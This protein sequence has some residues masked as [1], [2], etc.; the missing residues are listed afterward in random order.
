MP[1]RELN[2]QWDYDLKASP[3]ELW[4]FVSDTNR[5]NRD[6]GVPAVESDTKRHRLRNARRRL[7]LSI[8]GMAV[9]WEEQPFEWIR[10]SRFGVARTYSRG[11]MT[12]L[13][14]LAELTPRAGGG[15][16]LS[17]RVW[18][19]PRSLLGALVVRFQVRLVNAKRFARAFRKYDQIASTETS[20]PEIATAVDLAP[21][22]LDRFLSIREKL[23]ADGARADVVDLLLSFV[24][25]ADDYRVARIRPYELADEWNLPRRAVLETCLRSTR[26][27][28]FDLQWE[29][30]CPLCRGAGETGSS[31]RDISSQVHC[32]TCRIDFTV[33]FDRF[34]EVTFRPNALIRRVEVQQFCMGSP[35]FTPHIVAQ[36]LLP[37]QTQRAVS[38]PL[39]PGRY[40]LRALELAGGQDVNVSDDGQMSATVKITEAGWPPEEL[41]LATQTTLQIANNTA[42]EQLVILE[43]LA[44]SD[45][46]ATAAEV[47]ALQIFRDLFSSEA[48]R[49]GEQ[50]SVGTL[51]ILFTDLRNSTQLYRQIGDATAFG[52]VMNHFD[53]LKQAIGEEDGALVKTIGDAVM[54]VFRRPVSAL[55]SMLRAQQSLASPPEGVLPLTLKAGIHCGPCIAVTLNDRLDYFGSTVNLAARL[56]GLST[57]N[58]VV[59][60]RALYDDP[61]VRDLVASENLRAMPFEMLLKGFEEERFELWRV[62]KQVTDSSG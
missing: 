7:R 19:K 13:R 4:P 45:Q 34:V 21:A 17:Y 30:L 15:T 11:P 12:E 38:L 39:E 33:N 35:Q 16:K 2:F 50:I 41:K 51:T 36:Q 8:Y 28:L 23:I 14:A 24:Q 40:R 32:E 10:P 1:L 53:V 61:E 9:E 62:G 6:T 42:A 44:W 26:V 59:I 58:D 49:P 5:F 54:A 18:I 43:R 20:V 22:A 57:G 48:L 37:S 31:L 46:S 27:G 47:T 56:E 52:R 55:K 60:S 25:S 29:L 3:E